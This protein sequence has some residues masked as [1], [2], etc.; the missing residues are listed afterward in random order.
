MPKTFGK[1]LKEARKQQ[2]LKAMDVSKAAGISQSTYSKYENDEKKFVSIEDVRVLCAVLHIDANQLFNLDTDEFVAIS[3]D[4]S[5]YKQKLMQQLNS[6]ID[7]I[8]GT[9]CELLKGYVEELK[10]KEEEN[11]IELEYCRVK[12]VFKK[13]DPFK[14]IPLCCIIS[15]FISRIL[16]AIEEEFTKNG[17]NSKLVRLYVQCENILDSIYSK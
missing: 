7:E 14:L 6:C 13:N 15:K 4:G 1:I 16:D 5:S 10:F 12:C 9:D 11:T 3:N 2:G 8:K 17:F